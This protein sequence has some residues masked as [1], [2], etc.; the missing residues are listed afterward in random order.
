MSI[1]EYIEIYFNGN[2]S[3]FA[4]HMNVTPQQ[5][6]KWVNDGWII[7]DGRLYS[8][9]RNVSVDN[10]MKEIHFLAN[11]FCGAEYV[12]AEIRNLS[13]SGSQARE[14]A[15]NAKITIE[16]L[17][18]VFE[19]YNYKI[20]VIGYNP[21]LSKYSLYENESVFELGETYFNVLNPGSILF[22]YNDDMKSDKTFEI[23]G[24]SPRLMSGRF[25][26]YAYAILRNEISQALRT[27]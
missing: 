1:V 20:S 16:I 9:K 13:I 19:N 15:H 5:V 24:E 21:A 17:S 10:I 8:P 26:S 27:L 23:N 4:R 7:S 2:K 25:D 18:E 3:E 14:N 11:V 6:T 22:V 12:L